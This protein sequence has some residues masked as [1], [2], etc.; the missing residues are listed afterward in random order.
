MVPQ[1]RA[2]LLRANLGEGKVPQASPP[3]FNPYGRRE[4]S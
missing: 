2:R 3:E 4:M 1:V